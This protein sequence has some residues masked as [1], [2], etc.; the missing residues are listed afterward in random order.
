MINLGLIRILTT[1]DDNWMAVTADGNRSALLEHMYGNRD[2]RWMRDI[3]PRENEPVMKWDPDI[4]QRL[5]S[6]HIL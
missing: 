1:W 4:S 5:R 2:K 6:F 3:D